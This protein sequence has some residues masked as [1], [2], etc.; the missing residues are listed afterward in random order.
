MKK[1]Y[2]VENFKE[3]TIY[4]LIGIILLFLISF[5]YLIKYELYKYMFSRRQI[6]EVNQPLLNRRNTEEKS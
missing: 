5:T 4:I 1:T 3:I 6:Q 2:Q